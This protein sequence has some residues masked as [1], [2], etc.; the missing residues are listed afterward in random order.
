MDHLSELVLQR[1]EDWVPTCG[2]KDEVGSGESPQ[3]SHRLLPGSVHRENG[4]A[5]TGVERV[6]CWWVQSAD[7][8]QETRGEGRG[9]EGAHSEELETMALVE[10][11]VPRSDRLSIQL[12]HSL[13]LDGR[14]SGK[15]EAKEV[16]WRFCP[17]RPLLR[18]IVCSNLFSILCHTCICLLDLLRIYL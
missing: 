17:A 11:Q 12:Q 18:N 3:F 15:K 9:K 16:M 13:P 10:Y 1:T 4:E 2:G 8:G 6:W 14:R 5:R 7:P